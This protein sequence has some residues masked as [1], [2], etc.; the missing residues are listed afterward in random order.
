[1]LTRSDSTITWR[2]ITVYRFPQRNYYV[3]QLHFHSRYYHAGHYIGATGHLDV[4]LQLHRRGYGA[5]LT[6]A[7]VEAGISF[8]LARLWQ[9]PTWEEALELERRLHARHNGP[10]LCPICQH[11]PPCVLVEMRKGHWPFS[12]FAQTRP[13][14]PMTTHHPR[15]V[16]RE[17]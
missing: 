3:Y 11:R 1:M 8:E 13:R 16:H 6:K 17:R 10:L 15:F 2:G 4:R 14:R 5:K 7:V 12:L 9:V